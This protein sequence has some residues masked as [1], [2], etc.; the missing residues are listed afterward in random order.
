MGSIESI[1]LKWEDAK[2]SRSGIGGI[3]AIK[4]QIEG[5]ERL[6]IAAKDDATLDVS[7]VG[8]VGHRVTD[9][10]VEPQNTCVADGGP[11]AVTLVDLIPG[12]G[13]AADSAIDAAGI[14]RS[15]KDVVAEV[16]VGGGI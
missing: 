10:R 1:G 8:G 12:A 4:A 6:E 14:L 13:T 11:A 2:A 7:K 15:A 5:W 3:E 16:I 9:G